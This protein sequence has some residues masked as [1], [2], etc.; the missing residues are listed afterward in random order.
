MSKTR[1]S[2]G[3]VVSNGDETGEITAVNLTRQGVV[4][5]VVTNDEVVE[6]SEKD[7]MA[8]KGGAAIKASQLDSIWN[9]RQTTVLLQGCPAEQILSLS[10]QAFT[11]IR[12]TRKWF[13]Q[14]KVGDVIPCHTSV[15]PEGFEPSEDTYP[16]KGEFICEVLVTG[17]KLY[18]TFEEALEASMNN[19][20]VLA[21]NS[22]DDLKALIESIY[23]DTALKRADED[24]EDGYTVLTLEVVE[25]IEEAT[26][27]EDN[28]STDDSSTDEESVTKNSEGSGE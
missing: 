11:D 21:G 2:V 22:V 3:Q 13:D 12:V 5:E 1:F 16:G 6:M 26:E 28:D 15:K 7:L 4:Y 8:V 10:G 17:S 23:P 27:A 9:G 18:P 20:F 25:T 24:E 19:H 14:V